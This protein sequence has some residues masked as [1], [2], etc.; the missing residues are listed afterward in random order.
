MCEEFVKVLQ[1]DQVQSLLISLS[2]LFGTFFSKVDVISQKQQLFKDIIPIVC[3]IVNKLIS[4]AIQQQ[5]HT[6]QLQNPSSRN[7][8]TQNMVQLN[9][10]FITTF[11]KPFSF[12][13]YEGNLLQ[14]KPL[15]DVLYLMCRIA[16]MMRTGCPDNG[17]CINYRLYL[18]MA[19]YIDQQNYKI[20][21]RKDFIQVIK[22]LAREQQDS[23]LRLGLFQLIQN[24]IIPIATLINPEQSSLNQ[25]QTICNKFFEGTKVQS[26]F[27]PTL[28][29]LLFL[30]QQF[31]GQNL[32][33]LT[34]YEQAQL[35]KSSLEF[36]CACAG[37]L[38]SSETLIS[39]ALSTK[40]LLHQ[41]QE[42]STN[43]PINPNKPKKQEVAVVEKVSFVADI[44]SIVTQCPRIKKIL[45]QKGDKEG[46]TYLISGQVEIKD[47]ND[48]QDEI[49]EIDGPKQFKQEI[50]DVFLPILPQNCAYQV[51]NELVI[52]LV[53]LSLSYAARENE[54]QVNQVS[55]LLPAQIADDCRHLIGLPS[56]VL[57]V[58]TLFYE[59]FQQSVKNSSSL[60]LSILM[61]NFVDDLSLT[62]TN[63]I[64]E[65]I[66]VISFNRLMTLTNIGT[67][68]Q[69]LEKQIKNGNRDIIGIQQNTVQNNVQN[70]AQNAF[71]QISTQTKV[72]EQLMGKLNA[73][74]AGEYVMKLYQ[75]S[76][77][78][79]LVSNCCQDTKKIRNVGQYLIDLVDLAQT[80]C[81]EKQLLINDINEYSLKIYQ[82]RDE[83]VT[84][85]IA[86]QEPDILNFKQG[87][88]Q[89]QEFYNSVYAT[90]HAMRQ[91]TNL[92]LMY[93][94]TIEM[95]TKLL[96]PQ[97]KSSV[98][99][100]QQDERILFVNKMFGKVSLPSEH[101]EYF[102]AINLIQCINSLLSKIE[103]RRLTG[104]ISSDKVL[105]EQLQE[106]D[107]YFQMF[108][109]N[110]YNLHT[111]TSI[112]KA[113][114]HVMKYQQIYQK[115]IELAIESLMNYFFDECNINKVAHFAFSDQ[116]VLR[117][118]YMSLHYKQS[119][120]I[121]QLAL[122]HENSINLRFFSFDFQSFKSKCSKS[123]KLVPND[124]L[125]DKGNTLPQI[126]AVNRMSTVAIPDKPI[127]PG[128][129]NDNSLDQQQQFLDLFSDKDYFPFPKK[130]NRL[131]CALTMDPQL[132]FMTA[133]SN[134]TPGCDM[135][136]VSTAIYNLFA[137]LD[138]AI[139]QNLS[140]TELDFQMPQT[141]QMYIVLK[142]ALK[143]VIN[144]T[145]TPETLLRENSMGTKL[146][147]QYTK[148]MRGVDFLHR[149]CRPIIGICLQR[150]TI[151]FP[152]EIINK[153]DLCRFQE[154]FSAKAY[155][156]VEIDPTKIKMML[157]QLSMT[158]DGQK[159][160]LP[161]KLY[162]M[163]I[164]EVL[165]YNIKVLLNICQTIFNFILTN[166]RQVP[167]S[168][169]EIASLILQ[170]TQ[171]KFPNNTVAIRSAVSGFFFLR[172]ICPS[173]AS[174]DSDVYKII[175]PQED[176]SLANYDLVKDP[177]LKEAKLPKA[178]DTNDRR[179][180]I[181]VTK[182]I[183]NLANG[184]MFGAKEKFMLPFNDLIRNSIPKRNLFLDAL[185]ANKREIYIESDI[186]DY[187]VTT[188]M[189][190]VILE[191][192]EEDEDEAGDTAQSL[193]A[194][195]P[196]EID[197]SKVITDQ[198]NTSFESIKLTEKAEGTLAN[199]IQDNQQFSGQKVEPHSF[200]SLLCL[201]GIFTIHEQL[202]KNK[203]K[204][205][206]ELRQNICIK[207]YGP[208][209]AM[210]DY[211]QIVDELGQSVD[212]NKR[213]MS[214]NQPANTSNQIA[215]CPKIDEILSI[216]KK[217]P[218]EQLLV[219][220]QIKSAECIYQYGE[221]AQFKPVFYFVAQKL[222]VHNFLKSKYTAASQQYSMQLL[223][224]HA[225]NL[226]YPYLSSK[227]EIVLDFTAASLFDTSCLM[228]LIHQ[229]QQ[230]LPQDSKNNI[231]RIY[232]L[233]PSY[234]TRVVTQ[235]FL[236]KIKEI[237]LYRP[238]ITICDS[239]QKLQKL[240]PDCAVALPLESKRFMESVSMVYTNCIC[241]QQYVN[242]EKV[243]LA[244]NANGIITMYMTNASI[245]LKVDPKVTILPPPIQYCSMDFYPYN[246]F[247]LHVQDEQEIKQDKEISF[248]LVESYQSINDF[249][250]LSDNNLESFLAV[251][252]IC[253][254]EN[255]SD[256]SFGITDTQIAVK[257]LIGMQISSKQLR[258]ILISV[259]RIQMTLT[260]KQEMQTL[261]NTNIIQQ[262]QNLKIKLKSISKYKRIS[263]K[264]NPVYVL[265]MS[266]IGIYQADIEIRKKSYLSLQ[267]TFQSFMSLHLNKMLNYFD[268]NQIN[269]INYLSKHGINKIVQ[270][271]L[272][273]V[274]E[275]IPEIQI[276]LINAVISIAEYVNSRDVLVF[277]LEQLILKEDNK[278]KDV[279]L[280]ASPQELLTIIRSLIHFVVKYPEISD[281]AMN[282]LKQMTKNES[283]N[284]DILYLCF[285][286]CLQLMQSKIYETHTIIYI[287]NS[288]AT[289][290]E[291]L[292]IKAIEFLINSLFY[293]L[294]MR[295]ATKVNQQK[296]WTTY[297]Q[298]QQGPINL[299][300][301][302]DQQI[303][304]QIIFCDQKTEADTNI[305]QQLL[306]IIDVLANDQQI[307]ICPA[308]RLMRAISME[309]VYN[310]QTLAD[311]I[312]N[313]I[314]GQV[315]NQCLVISN[316]IA[317][318]ALRSH[319]A[320]KQLTE[321]RAKL[322][323]ILA[324][325][326]KSNLV[327][328]TRYS[329]TLLMQRASDFSQDFKLNQEDSDQKLFAQNVSAILN[330]LLQTQQ[331]EI[332]DD[333]LALFLSICALEFC[334]S[335]QQ[336]SVFQ[337][338]DNA[339]ES[340]FYSSLLDLSSQ[341]WLVL[342]QI[343]SRQPQVVRSYQ[344][345]AVKYVIKK[346]KFATHLQNPMSPVILRLIF[347]FQSSNTLGF[348]EFIKAAHS[349][350]G[351][352]SIAELFS[353]DEKVILRSSNL[354]NFL[355]LL[356]LALETE[357]N[358]A[359]VVKILQALAQAEECDVC[360]KFYEQFQEQLGGTE[361]SLKMKNAIVAL[362]A[363]TKTNGKKFEQEWQG[364]ICDLVFTVKQVS[365]VEET[366]IAK[367]LEGNK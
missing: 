153:L 166:Y 32:G 146:I 35:F 163:L 62:L 312:V 269:Q 256:L 180:L 22:R 279:I 149:F 341:A 9:I 117:D 307:N 282:I 72:D 274:N 26:F 264:I 239:L 260:Q 360:E 150:K 243:I 130:Y 211:Q 262:N 73:Q 216:T 25:I 177:K 204:I 225:L 157:P 287:L 31:K 10:A 254:T 199:L 101:Y 162:E 113:S 159:V 168:S 348:Q 196:S 122:K 182:I 288:F 91:R 6:T 208:N 281:Q 290:S 49:D 323:K 81:S 96:D 47:D 340:Q 203:I 245:Q 39:A 305:I 54:I 45:Q 190:K 231:N 89:Y 277:M 303:L 61:Q 38:P 224:M 192:D 207:Q 156:D 351:F 129:K 33:Q 248:S 165:K 158:V 118:C 13:I 261:T 3:S 74:S 109:D 310:K 103:L 329:T 127:K 5:L 259:Q 48:D 18:Q 220:Q 4:C 278:V 24:I 353:S 212:G 362:Q 327:S 365:E 59:V 108:M 170:Y 90:S 322:L 80:F 233:N 328:M 285:K 120:D 308:A 144:N 255:Y 232:V 271:V 270:K 11:I 99:M 84:K 126:S 183:Q 189:I 164:K 7:I 2:G 240:V 66:S 51:A 86:I 347:A 69:G 202:N 355:I 237:D 251:A 361:T 257:R 357:E 102:D 67:G 134:S 344:Q 214:Q 258:S 155:N 173:L 40:L 306:T 123:L 43:K 23:A 128:K 147:W 185:A 191:D 252:D 121:K 179:R 116:K 246:R 50:I 331:K 88:T 218:K 37:Q 223:F 107:K 253:C 94:Q 34:Y 28:H 276:T 131:V 286:E 234:N 64:Q 334:I 296:Q 93:F 142:N 145:S 171:Q 325:L 201:Q 228:T 230:V 176:I 317:E 97:F 138:D 58:I 210:N 200:K 293:E 268:S 154:E 132:Q 112:Q 226:L 272:K 198:V 20:L 217:M 250:T 77:S 148:L 219:L 30:F 136:S 44:S 280:Q 326:I 335:Q 294:F 313:L 194:A 320:S 133:I 265:A 301:V 324:A 8:L 56:L 244:Q 304:A 283:Q 350:P 78:L 302:L 321:F 143:Y 298:K 110:L 68:N 65:N 151:E 359:L 111:E 95:I 21:R 55:A 140:Y 267:N 175:D 42:K 186:K 356:E 358:D 167:E 174:P 160:P 354:Q 197:L 14:N 85:L 215:Q 46:I 82:Q 316:F 71:A 299:S 209:F 92:G 336:S 195:Q 300:L 309:F 227:I 124:V 1:V 75:I 236:N 363:T 57:N 161:K 242:D 52:I 125:A 114:K 169:F 181:L 105:K 172:F 15:V 289:Q 238:K 17:F 330:V 16:D 19:G 342:S 12:S 247:K 367:Y 63:D 29:Q 249:S 76:M 193:E 263:H 104:M 266:M 60:Y 314:K 332:N 229:I 100:M 292:K 337:T 106:E 338:D 213:G 115:E 119:W 349:Y 206:E 137:Y 70:A 141:H 139:R 178:L 297:V 339:Q 318:Q 241:K 87:V 98:G 319:G 315:D 36:V 295:Y 275:T 221:S 41:V 79:S 184:V 346:N 27:Q 345:S 364:E 311:Q 135:D 235:K 83:N 152:Q 284:V 333:P 273:S 187:T 188:E 343:F 222:N 352:E 291:E 366:V 205:L 53:G